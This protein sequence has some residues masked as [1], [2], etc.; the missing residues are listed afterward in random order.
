MNAYA[1]SATARGFV[2]KVAQPFVDDHILAIEAKDARIA[3]L[4]ALC[5]AKDEKIADLQADY[6]EL[7]QGCDAQTRANEDLRFQLALCQKELQEC[8]AAHAADAALDADKVL[9][10]AKFALAN[11][12]PYVRTGWDKLLYNANKHGLVR[13]F[14]ENVNLDKKPVKGNG[15]PVMDRERLK[16]CLSRGVPIYSMDNRVPEGLD[17][18]SD[19][20][21]QTYVPYAEYQEAQEQFEK[22]CPK[23]TRHKASAYKNMSRDPYCDKRAAP[24]GRK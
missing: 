23:F 17:N 7:K 22:D 13:P 19:N 10:Q 18:T 14:Y 21:R 8:I 3:E 20:R 2:P 16:D 1:F 9:A 24:R 15:E 11:V 5:A 4:E 6:D 12:E